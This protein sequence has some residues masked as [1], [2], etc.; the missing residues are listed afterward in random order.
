V[1]TPII[2]MNESLNQTLFGNIFYKI[3]KPDIF[4]NV[5]FFFK[6]IS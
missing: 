4:D 5:V 2:F 1:H 3:K 6:L